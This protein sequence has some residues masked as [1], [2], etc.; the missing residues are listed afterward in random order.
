MV[1][2]RFIRHR[3]RY[4]TSCPSFR[5]P[6]SPSRRRSRRRTG[7]SW[8]ISS[9]APPPAALLST[10]P[11]TRGS[12]P[13]RRPSW[14]AITSLCSTVAASGATRVTGPGGT[15]R[16]IGN[17]YTR[18]SMP[19]KTVWRRATTKEGRKEKEGRRRGTRKG[20]ISTRAS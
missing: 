3:R 15:S 12:P 11:A 14:T 9:P 17:E 16:R 1:N 6:S 4:Q 19:S 5:P 13:P 18:S 10:F 8:P 2:R 20:V 7:K